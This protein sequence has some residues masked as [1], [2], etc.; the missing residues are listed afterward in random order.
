MYAIKKLATEKILV[1]GLQISAE[2]MLL[3]DYVLHLTRVVNHVPMVRNTIFKI[4]QLGSSKN[5]HSV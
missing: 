5:V 3:G 4:L 2:L 1:M